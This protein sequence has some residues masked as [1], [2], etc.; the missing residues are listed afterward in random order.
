MVLRSKSFGLWS[1]LMLERNASMNRL[2]SRFR[3]APNRS[4]LEP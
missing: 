2:I 1:K 3:Q 4:S